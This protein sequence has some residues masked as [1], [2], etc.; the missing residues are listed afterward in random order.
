VSTV[1][2]LLPT[3]LPALLAHP[4]LSSENT[5][6]PRERLG[7]G[8]S[9]ATL[10][11]MADQLRAFARQRSAWVSMRRQRLLGLVGARQRG[12]NGAWEIDYLLDATPESRVTSDLL[13]YVVAQAGKDGAQKVFL[14]LPADSDLL[15]PVLESGFLA[16]QEETLFAGGVAS[17]PNRETPAGLRGAAASDSYPLFRLYCTATPES[18][19]RFEAATFD[20]WHDA[21]ERRWLR[22][23]LHLVLERDSR[24]RGQVRVSRLPQGLMLDLLI[25]SEA[26]EDAAGLL[27]AAVAATESTAE[28]V[29]V[30]LPQ[31]AEGVARAL[32]SDGFIA[33][34]RY[35]SLMRRTTKPLALPRKV[36]VV[37]KNAI[38]V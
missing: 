1:R 13:E 37:A 34:T 19:R 16:Y 38:G 25:D 6:F 33:S 8:D 12:G 22:N 28:P 27:S 30:L 9:Q 4:G 11:V 7:A 23:G 29:L 15:Q 32:Q 2:T 14:R 36:P 21:Q 5:A 26:S 3:D 35:V 24:L 18:T 10:S 20:E 31:A 17:V